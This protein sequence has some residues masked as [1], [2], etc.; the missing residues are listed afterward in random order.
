MNE[1]EYEERVE[2]FEDEKARF[3][4]WLEYIRPYYFGKFEIVKT[5]SYNSNNYPQYFIALPR[6]GLKG[7]YVWIHKPTRTIK[8]WYHKERVLQKRQDKGYAV[9]RSSDADELIEKV[10]AYLDDSNDC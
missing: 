5:G 4:R 6:K 8:N 10:D 3:E 9:Y 2:G 7:A 1:V